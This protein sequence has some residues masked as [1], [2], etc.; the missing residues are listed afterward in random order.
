MKILVLTKGSSKSGLGHLFRTST[1]V[2]YAS[3]RHDVSVVAVLDPDLHEVIRDIADCTT[4]VAA[5]G[6]VPQALMKR[7][8]DV[9]V[10]DFVSMDPAAWAAVSVAGRLRVSLSPVF[11]HADDVDLLFTRTS[12][13]GTA[14]SCVVYGGLEY[15]VFS[16]H[17]SVIS[18]EQ[19]F[20]NL[21]RSDLPI[22]ICMGGA[23]AAN[24]TLSVLRALVDIEQVCM[25]WVLLGEG[26]L[27]S[28]NDLVEVTKRNRRHEIILAKTNRSMWK[29][30][31]N[32][33]LAVL[34][35]GLTTVEAIYAGL[36]TIN[37]FER[38]EHLDAMSQELF[39]REVCMDGGFFREESLTA[40]RFTMQEL[41][42]R[43][44]RLLSMR[45]NTKGVVDKRGCER[46]L[47]KIEQ[48]A[49][50]RGA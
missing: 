26:Y 43:K 10:F 41:M 5:D 50:A 4:I 24:K 6:E 29:I 8:P 1:F 47:E 25:F 15:A 49:A 34:A 42:K 12:N 18:D 45:E 17:C 40:L 44:S 22:G 19:Y 30:L 14:G 39:D 13:N 21:G 37:L 28:Y 3:Q 46:I 23:D 27:H 38:E 7:S 2:K 48:H 16:E 9:I 20:A 31:G 11:A 33:A 32:C 36:P 35:G